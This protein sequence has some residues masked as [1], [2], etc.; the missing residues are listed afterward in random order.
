MF[1][2]YTPWKHIKKTKTDLHWL[3][4]GWVGWTYFY[5]ISYELSVWKFRQGYTSVSIATN[6]ATLLLS[7]G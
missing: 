5:V 2:F 6:T 7:G 4:A 3:D 1:P